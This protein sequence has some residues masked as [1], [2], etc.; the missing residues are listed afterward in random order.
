MVIGKRPGVQPHHAAF[1]PVGDITHH[2]GGVHEGV[3]A[4]DGGALSAEFEADGL[5]VFCGG[6]HEGSSGFEASGECSLADGWVLQNRFADER[7]WTC[8]DVEDAGWQDVGGQLQERVL[9]VDEHGNESWVPPDRLTGSGKAAVQ[10]E[11][12]AV[13][14]EPRTAPES[15]TTANDSAEAVEILPQEAASFWSTMPGC[16]VVF[17]GLFWAVGQFI[18]GPAVWIGLVFNAPNSAPIASVLAVDIW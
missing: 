4:D 14:V 12:L 11:A 8:D 7:A 15:T 1:A 13:E 16:C 18:I 10:Q 2:G 6:G 3:F 5:E 9:A 17:F